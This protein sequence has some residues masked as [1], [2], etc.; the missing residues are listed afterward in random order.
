MSHT[1]YNVYVIV[2]QSKR[3][4]CTYY[5]EFLISFEKI[6]TNIFY[7]ISFC[8][9]SMHLCFSNDTKCQLALMLAYNSIISLY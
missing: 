2:T 1:R 8:F 3:I 5:K 9:L 4:G 6:L 7:M